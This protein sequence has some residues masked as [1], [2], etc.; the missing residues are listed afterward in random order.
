MR[1]STRKA[2]LILAHA[3]LIVSVLYLICYLLYVLFPG[4]PLKAYRNFFLF[5]YFYLIIPILCLASGI[6]L[7]ISATKPKR[8]RTPKN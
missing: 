8:R 5:D 3:G 7:Q 1:K 2:T 4:F 6:L